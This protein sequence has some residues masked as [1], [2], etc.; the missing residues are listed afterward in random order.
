MELIKVPAHIGCEGCVFEE[1]NEK[2]PADEQIEGI[3]IGKWDAKEWD[4]A[5]NNYIW[6]V[7]N[8]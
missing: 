1:Q 4:C 7:K 6:K 2:C 3:P 8:E 5:I